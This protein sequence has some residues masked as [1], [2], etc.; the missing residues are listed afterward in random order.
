MSETPTAPTAPAPCTTSASPA[1]YAG[2]ACPDCGHTL[3]AHP[4]AINP[5]LDE[6]VL[7]SVGILLDDLV[8]WSSDLETRLEVLEAAQVPPAPA[9]AQA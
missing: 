4:G 5:A 2:D 8:A 1:L 3:L 9:E 7:C 6:C